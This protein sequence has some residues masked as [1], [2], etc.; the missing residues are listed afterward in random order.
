MKTIDILVEVTAEDIAKG[1]PRRCS[2][3]P[4]ALALRRATGKEWIV[5]T[6]MRPWTATDAIE[7]PAEAL[8]FI[9]AFDGLLEEVAPFSFTL[10]VPAEMLAEAQP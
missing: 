9:E 6:W 7:T 1:Q 5:G 3:C 8:A 2:L 4:V 10:A